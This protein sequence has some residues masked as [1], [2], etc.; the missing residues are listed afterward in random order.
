MR[1]ALVLAVLLA[2]CKAPEAPGGF[3]VD[4]TVSWVNVR[5]ADRARATAVQI[6]VGGDE[7]VDQMLPISAFKGNELHVRYVPQIA[8]GQLS[9]VAGLLAADGSSIA[10]ADGGTV[11][12]LPGRAVAVMLKLGAATT[13]GGAC[14]SGLQCGTPG[15]CVDG[16]C[17]MQS[18]CPDCRQ[19][20]TSG[21]CDVVISNAE[22]GA[23]SGTRMCDGAGDCKDKVG[24]MCTMA[25]S[26][27]TGQCSDG[28]C[29]DVDCSG[30]CH[31]CAPSGMG[32][33][34]T[35]VASAEDPDSCA[36]GM[37][38]AFMCNE[39]AQ[40]RRP[41]LFADLNQTVGLP[42]NTQPSNPSNFTAGPKGLI[43][44][45][46]SDGAAGNELWVTDGSPTGTHM[47]KDI[48]VGL[49]NGSNPQELTVFGDAVYF[50][51]TD[52][53]ND[54][55]LFRSDGTAAG[56]FVVQ[57]IMPVG[58]ATPHDLTVFNGA[59]YFAATGNF[60]VNVPVGEELWK[61]DG[62][63]AGTVLV[64]DILGGPLG[65]QPGSLTVLNNRLVFYASDMIATVGVNN[66]P[67]NRELWG[68]GGTAITTLLIRDLTSGPNSTSFTSNLEVVGTHALFA[69]NADPA[70]GWE[71]YATDG[72]SPGT[73]LV[74]DIFPGA[75]GSFP[76]Q[77]T[78]AGGELFFTASD[79]THGVELY[80]SDATNAG[81]VLVKDIIP[82]STSSVPGSLTAVGSDV[83]FSTSDTTIGIEP[84]VSD[85]TDA[86][87]H[88]VKDIAGPPVAN[89]YP[90]GFAGFQGKVFF[91]ATPDGNTLNNEL[92][93]T[94]GTA[95]GTVPACQGTDPTKLCL[96]T[97]S[98]P[99]AIGGHLYYTG[100]SGD[101]RYGAEPFVFP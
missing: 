29:C 65:S 89:S 5:A 101:R 62:T 67:S 87:T 79:G 52:S 63:A 48:R 26:C 55:K 45:T 97:N 98:A 35:P 93:V 21:S 28:L 12:L 24:Q 31:T 83:Y 34:C 72:T 14:T 44:F 91:E 23:C 30:P 88:L 61:S 38:G 20:G 17:C 81:T 32:G 57:D 3:G 84:W 6:S 69:A 49:N 33:T 66:V 37:G 95:A 86:G 4:L 43:F 11:Q 53:D 82:G 58:N 94:D 22:L 19:C 74:K 41:H 51:A 16:V 90:H 78:P 59:L 25:D 99:V 70:T 60:P 71:L 1:R 54:S 39:G 47:V 40:C 100:D 64:K 15:G 56:T 73:V 50:R 75:T 2:G 76:N 7:K 36:I 96:A 18:S 42:G 10:F 9:F 68:S 13:P 46:A 8:G 80:K 77:L 27:A 85:G 92:W